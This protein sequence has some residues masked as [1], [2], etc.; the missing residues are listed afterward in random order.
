[1][2]RFL[3]IRLLQAI[4]VLLVMSVITFIIIQAPPGDYA[5]FLRTNMIV[6]GNATVE[7]AT[8]FADEYRE[9]NGLNDPLPLQYIRWIWGIVTQLDFGQ[10]YAY[11]RPV[12]DV[13]LAALR[14]RERRRSRPVDA[15]SARGEAH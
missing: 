5:D 8:R 7:A 6:Q 4:P 3:A 12:L 10:S 15:P 14:G 1:M 2:L 9:R 11:N 13:V